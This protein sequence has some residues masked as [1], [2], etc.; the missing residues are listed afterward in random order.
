M[1]RLA[2]MPLGASFRPNALLAISAPLL[3]LLTKAPLSVKTKLLPQNLSRAQLIK[4][5][6]WLVAVGLGAQINTILTSWARA[7]WIMGKGRGKQFGADGW[8][9]EVA[10]VTGGSNGIGALIAK[11]LAARGIK[12]AIL[13][14]AEPSEED[15]KHSMVSR[16]SHRMSLNFQ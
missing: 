12:V 16:C 2:A 11:G 10:V 7:N 8:G 15:S 6:A 4:F 3:V 1:Y 14:I 5:I 9:Q 13:D